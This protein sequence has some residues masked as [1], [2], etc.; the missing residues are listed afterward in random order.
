[1]K[2][3]K[4]IVPILTS[5][6]IFLTLVLTIIVKGENDFE[7]KLILVYFVIGLIAMAYSWL[8]QKFKMNLASNLFLFFS[9]LSGI[10]F[11]ISM[12]RG[13]EGLSQLA[14]F[15]SWIMLMIGSL[16]ITLFVGLILK[17]KDINR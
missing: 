13:P 15:L 5:L 16:V 12:P 6:T 9:F 17:W 1:M 4:I 10:Y 8:L 2:K 11:Y 3:S 7:S 14:A